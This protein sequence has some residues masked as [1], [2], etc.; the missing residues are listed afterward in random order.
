MT[1]PTVQFS[2]RASATLSNA[3]ASL[4]SSATF[5]AGYESAV[6]DNS[7]NLDDNIIVSGHYTV[8]TTPTIN[9]QI[10][11]WI[12]PWEDDTPTWPD[13]FDGTESAET[14][15]S[16]G[17]LSGFGYSAFTLNVDAT[18]SNRV[19]AFNFSILRICGFV[20]KKSVLFSAHNTGVNFNSTGGNHVTKIQGVSW[21]IPSL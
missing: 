6:I 11:G 20:P 10:L 18:T 1:T 9:T 14:V 2:Y 8:G 19:Y 7:S 15:T 21:I 12:I 5:V 16:A 17:V 3:V 13:V 4:G